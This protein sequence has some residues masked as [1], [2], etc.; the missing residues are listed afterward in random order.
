M[1]ATSAAQSCSATYSRSGAMRLPRPASTLPGPHSTT[2]FTPFA[3]NSSIVSIQRT[4]LYSCSTSAWR[5]R[6]G[7][8]DAATKRLWITGTAGLRTST[9]ARRS[10][11]RSAAGFIRLQ[12]DGALMG[13]ITARL[14]PFCFAIAMPRSTAARLPAMTTWP[15]EFRLAGSS[16]SPCAASAHTCASASP[17]RPRIAAM[18]PVPSGTA[19]CIA[20]AR[21]RTSGSASSK[22]NACAAMSALYSPRLWPASQPGIGPPLSRH[23]RQHATPATSMTGCVF[24]VWFNASAGPSVTIV[25]R[26]TPRIALA[27][28]NVRSTMGRSEKP[29]IM[30]T[31]WEPCPGNTIASE[32]TRSMS[33]TQQH[34]APGEAAA[35]ALEQ[36]VVAGLHAAVAHGDVERERDRRRRRVGVAIDGDDA[37]RLG[38]AELL[39]DVG[40]DAH[41]RL[42]RNVDVEVVDGHGVGRERLARVLLEHAHREPEDRSAIHL[43]RRIA[44]DGAAG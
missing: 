14:A 21:K 5:M 1:A 24:T 3:R 18:P 23:A 10:A 8:S 36:H 30:P 38:K 22:R 37:F 9:R 7:S 44:L 19:S 4:G 25:H 11:R 42:V 40:D 34:R 32:F 29:A 27:S 17:S 20:W 6:S 39:R 2:R 15:G 28:R 26:S 13:S 43:E 33:V 35:D 41:V 16:T 12:C 31:D